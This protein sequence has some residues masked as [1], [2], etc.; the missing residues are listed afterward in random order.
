MLKHPEASIE[1]G[2][3][4]AGILLYRMLHYKLANFLLRGDEGEQE[5]CAEL[6]YRNGNIYLVTSLAGF[7]SWS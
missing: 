5:Y 7:F 6:R 2:V 3:V 1:D 4:L